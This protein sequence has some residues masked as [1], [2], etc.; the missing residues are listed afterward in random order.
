MQHEDIVRCKECGSRELEKD[1]TRG[2]LTCL[3]CGL[4]LEDNLV[5]QGAEWRKFDDGSGSDPARTGAPMNIMLHDKGLSTDIDWQNR[6]WSG[7][8]LKSNS[9]MHRMR[10]WQRRSRVSSSRER[11]LQ[12][13]L[14]ELD[15]M[16][17]HLD[18]LPKSV[19]QEAANVY[20]RTLEAGLV[21]GRS[22]QGAVAASL[23]IA[24]QQCGVPRTLDEVSQKLRLGR[25]EIGRTV[26]T[27]KRE[28]RMKPM[29]AKA[30]D[31]IDRFCSDLGLAQQCKTLCS[32]WMEEIKRLE[33]DSGRGPVGIA[34]ALIYMASIVTGQNR[35]QREIAETTNVTEVTI[36][37]RYKELSAA[38]NIEVDN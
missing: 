6:D 33:L 19:R 16:A 27:L 7:K 18:G 9:Q 36:R 2:E 21:R 30:S 4:V 10:K 17:M 29:H 12:S 8:A 34:A 32:E 5:D 31:Y 15:K 22:I 14:S 3:V 20:K 1:L 26:R 23:Y 11:N 13:A 37:N 28:L 24:C 38:L 35:T 25:K